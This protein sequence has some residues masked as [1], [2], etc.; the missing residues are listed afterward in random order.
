MLR[1]PY[2]GVMTSILVSVRIHSSPA[3]RATSTGVVLAFAYLGHGLGGWQGGFFFDL[4]GNYSWTYANA[5]L[6][7][8]LNLVIVSA[9]WLKMNRRPSAA[10]AA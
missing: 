10:V 9:L 8:I 5:A 1:Q 3:R 7:G 2:A 4:T 6:A